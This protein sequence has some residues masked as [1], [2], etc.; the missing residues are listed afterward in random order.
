MSEQAAE[1][2]KVISY[3]QFS[4]WYKCPHRWYLDHV[5]GMKIFEDSIQMIFGTAIHG[6]I[7]LYLKTLYTKG[8][9]P[10]ENIDK[11]KYFKHM[12]ALLLKQRKLEHTQSDFIQYVMDGENIL[13][14]FSQTAKRIK[15]FP[16][17][18]YEF[19]DVEHEILVDIMNNVQMIAYLDLVLKEKATG[20]IKII[21]IK[22]SATGWNAYM[23]E[24]ES[25]TAQLIMYK[26]LYSKK[27]GIPLKMIDIEFFIVKRK[28]YEGVS[29]PQERIQ[30]FVP[31]HHESEVMKTIGLFTTFVGECFTRDGKYR[32]DRK[33][34]KIP[35]KY[36]KNC[37]FCP[38]KKVNCDAFA[39]P[40]EE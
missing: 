4:N 30:I 39:D 32:E 13:K 11:M 24:D 26:A 28:L 27:Y 19:I 23:K 14:E 9:V 15:H 35:G 18:K 12:F 2:K 34:P 40:L 1:K 10:A 6:T 17:E 21:D 22:T 16:T 7:Q 31:R 25:K 5:K 8:L 3:S 38:H 37:K 20:K 36:K 29:Y 33:Y